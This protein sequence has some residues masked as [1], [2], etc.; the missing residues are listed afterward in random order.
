MGLAKWKL[1]VPW[2]EKKEMNF[3]ENMAIKGYKLKSVWSFKYTF[4]ETEPEELVYKCD[5]RDVKKAEIT[6]Y[7]QIFEDSGWENVGQFFNYFYFCREQKENCQLEL[8]NDNKYQEEKNKRLISVLLVMAISVFPQNVYTI[9]NILSENP[10]L[11]PFYIGLRILIALS[12]GFILFGFIK[13]FI[14]YRKLSNNMKE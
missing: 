11:D 2:N 12:T 14:Q 9:M 7:L 1:F 5:Y 13:I 8:F 4:Y 10:I 6:E 3:L